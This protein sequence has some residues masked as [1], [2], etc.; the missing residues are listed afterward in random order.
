[1]INLLL[2]LS[3]AKTLLSTTVSSTNY[4]L[5]NQN[6]LTMTGNDAK[7]FEIWEDDLFRD[8]YIGIYHSYKPIVYAFVNRIE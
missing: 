2:G 1:M 4:M 5:E 7:E 8:D 6:N 3:A